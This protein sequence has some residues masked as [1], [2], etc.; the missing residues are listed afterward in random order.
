ME[1]DWAQLTHETAMG[2]PSG[3][4]RSVPNLYRRSL[5]NRRSLPRTTACTGRPATESLMYI[6]WGRG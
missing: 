3:I 4:D 6:E 2:W 5:P 1:S